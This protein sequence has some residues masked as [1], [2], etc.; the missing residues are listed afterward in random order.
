MKQDLSNDWKAISSYIFFCQKSVLSCFVVVHKT[1][2][3]QT[4][5]G[6]NKRFW[7][8][9]RFYE[10]TSNYLSTNK[11]TS[12]SWQWCLQYC[13]E[14][15]SV[16]IPYMFFVIAFLSNPNCYFLCDKLV[17]R[18]I[19]LSI[20][21]DAWMI[22]N[23]SHQCQVNLPRGSE[24]KSVLLILWINV[25]HNKSFLYPG[26]PIMQK[27]WRYYHPFVHRAISNQWIFKLSIKDKTIEENL[28]IH[29]N[30][31]TIMSQLFE[32]GHQLRYTSNQLLQNSKNIH[33][34]PNQTKLMHCY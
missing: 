13:S 5:L 4:T 31:E 33:L 15:K 26:S 29:D 12:D 25:C 22:Y 7:I 16:Y 28:D 20:L 23:R 1:T 8:Y 3:Q 14:Q 32:V 11:W 10:S 19:L 30:N 21:Q 9:R 6:L 18:I 34:S 2:S 24:V 27:K 17:F